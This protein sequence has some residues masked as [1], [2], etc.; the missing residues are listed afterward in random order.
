MT[1][2][3]ALLCLWK[4]VSLPC[5]RVHS[6]ASSYKGTCQWMEIVGQS[7]S[8]LGDSTKHLLSLLFAAAFCV[9]FNQVQGKFLFKN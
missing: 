8:G 5:A 9:V 7:D 1:L 6:G 3:A 2:R 4:G